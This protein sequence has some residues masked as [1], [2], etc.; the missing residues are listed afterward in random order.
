[1]KR[2]TAGLGEGKLGCILWLVVL[3]VAGLVA[4]RAIPIKVASS[5]LYDYMDDQARFGA[6]T[7]AENLKTRIFKRAQELDLPVTKKNITVQKRGGMVRM[8][9]IFTAPVNILGYTYNWDFNLE[10]ERQIFIF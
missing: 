4:Y 8:T 7:S 10:L 9:C 3:L 6:R 2:R 1:L 5:Q